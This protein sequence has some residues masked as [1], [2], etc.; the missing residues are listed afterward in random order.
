MSQIMGLPADKLLEDY[1]PGEK[2]VYTF[3]SGYL[4]AIADMQ[5]ILDGINDKCCVIAL[6]GTM[7]PNGKREL[8]RRLKALLEDKS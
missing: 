1:T 3:D 5:K 2:M 7:Y 6:D 4:A 8:K